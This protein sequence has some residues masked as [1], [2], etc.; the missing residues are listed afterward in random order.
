MEHNAIKVQNALESI[1]LNISMQT[2]TH[3]HTHTH[4][5]MYIY[6]HIY[7]DTYRT[8]PVVQQYRL[9]FQYERY[10]RHW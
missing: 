4:I 6:M 8:S 5:Y 2:D 10:R 7:I 9:H 3:T 1:M